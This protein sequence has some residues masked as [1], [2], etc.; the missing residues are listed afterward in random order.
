MWTYLHADACTINLISVSFLIANDENISEITRES[1]NFSKS[2]DTIITFS[3]ETAILGPL[4]KRTV[5]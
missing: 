2:P 4:P 5:F 1:L 3:T